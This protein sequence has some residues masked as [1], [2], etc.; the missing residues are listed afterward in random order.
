MVTI[1]V[2]WELGNTPVK[3]K[4]VTLST[5][6]GQLHGVTNSNGDVSFDVPGGKRYKVYIDGGKGSYEGPIVGV[7]VVYVR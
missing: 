2:Y 3:G 6:T 7:Q 5:N 1:R 4:K